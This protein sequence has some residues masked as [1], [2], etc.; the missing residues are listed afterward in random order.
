MLQL[1]A[2][3]GP[4]VIMLAPVDFY[5]SA[6]VQNIFPE[7]K[8]QGYRKGYRKGAICMLWYISGL[9][10]QIPNNH[11]VF[12]YTG[13]DRSAFTVIGAENL[14]AGRYLNRHRSPPSAAANR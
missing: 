1:K 5:F 11:F 8:F 4:F 12:Q 13:Q 14:T 7:S 3:K 10:G 2:P 9:Q 6:K